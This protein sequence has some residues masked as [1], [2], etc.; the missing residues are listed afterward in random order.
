MGMDLQSIEEQAMLDAMRDMGMND[1]D[2]SDK[3]SQEEASDLPSK[4][5]Y[6]LHEDQIKQARADKNNEFGAY[7]AQI[8]GYVE[9]FVT[10]KIDVVDFANK[11]NMANLSFREMPSGRGRKGNEFYLLEGA[12]SVAMA[13]VDLNKD[14]L[15]NHQVFRSRVDRVI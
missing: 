5:K 7:F 4:K 11:I 10:S 3:P 6:Y 2:S 9:D 12:L 8:P 1:E 13:I 15:Q 14:S